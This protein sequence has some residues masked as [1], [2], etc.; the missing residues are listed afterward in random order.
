MLG[1]SLLYGIDKTAW[2]G[3]ELAS[4]WQAKSFCTTQ[5]SQNGL[6]I[7][8]TKR[9]PQVLLQSKVKINPSKCNTLTYTYRAKGEMPLR[10]QLYY[11]HDGENFSDSMKWMLPPLITDEKWHTVTLTGTALV[12]AWSWFSDEPI[13]S[14]R[15]DPTDSESGEVE[16]SEIAFT[17]TESGMMRVKKMPPLKKYT[18][19][20][21]APAWD[22]IVPGIIPPPPSKSITDY[23]YFTGS[24]ISSPLDK[25]GKGEYTR[26]NMRR[27]INLKAKPVLAMIQYTGDDNCHCLINGNNVGYMG[28]WRQIIPL[29]VTDKLVKGKN[30]FGF[31]YSNT[32]NVGG[33][34][35][36]LF[37]R[38]PDGTSEH[39]NT[40][41][42]FR[43][44]PYATTK[45]NWSV[46]NY[47]ASKWAPVIC[48]PAPPGPPW[49]AVLPYH[50]YEHSSTQILHAVTVNPQ[51]ANAGE[52]VRV[53]MEFNGKKP[54][55]PFISTI[56]LF[57][58]D[59]KLLWEE[60]REFQ[61]K[62]VKTI[63]KNSWKLVFDYEVPMYLNSNKCTLKI[64]SNIMDEVHSAQFSIK[65]LK[66]IPGFEKKPS[67]QIADNNGS[68]VIKLN[69]KQ[70]YPIW[71]GVQRNKRQDKQPIHNNGKIDIVT[72]YVEYNKV[73]S[74]PD[75]FSTN[76]YD[77]QAEAYRRNNPDAYFIV[78]I[79][80]YPPRGWDKKYPDEMCTDDNGVV[81]R[82]GGRLNHSF[83]S[84]HYLKDTLAYLEK[85]LA[86]LENCPYAN[87]IIGYRITG[88]H[89]LEWLGWDPTDTSKTLDFSPA[90][91]KAFEA[92][93]RKHYPE[94]KDF[95]IPTIEEREALDGDEILWNQHK[96]LKSVA[97]ADF[98][99]DS[100]V[101]PM[102]AL[103]KRAKQIV[104]NDKL[105]GLYYGYTMTLGASGRSQP[106]AHYTLKKVLEKANGSID[107]VISPH[108]YALRN[109]GDI[110]GD[111]KPF[112]TLAN[113]GMLAVIEDDSRTFTCAAPANSSIGLGY[114]HTFNERTTVETLR[115]NMADTLCRNYQYYFYNLSAGCE[116]D[117]PQAEKD[118]ATMRTVGQHCVENHIRRGAEVALVAS[119]ESIKAMP[120]LRKS[121]PTGE[122]LQKYL[123]DGS[124]QT[125]GQSA[126]AFT[127]DV[128][129]NNYIRFARSGAAMDY[130]LAEDL[131]DNPG[132]YKL[133]VFLNCVKY[134]DAFLK[135]IE[136][137]RERNCTML[138]IYA[139]GYYHN[140]DNGV[141][142]M[143]RLTG[144]NFK[145][146]DGPLMPS[147]T[148][149]NGRTMG[150]PSTRILPMFQVVDKNATVLGKY[151]DDSIGLAFKK[152]GNATSIYSGVWKFDVSFLTWVLKTA[153]VHVFSESSDPVDANEALFTLHARFPGLKNI[154]LPRKTTVLDIFNRKIIGKDIDAFEYEAPLHETRFFYYGDDAELLL[155]KLNASAR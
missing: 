5:R 101:N 45:G 144:F 42:D 128:L 62:E 94:L 53:T 14:L 136:K 32:D 15:L 63:D 117:F 76:E 43:T 35:G 90:C 33:C 8:I 36:E 79:Q 107:F 69:G 97:Y 17:F 113:H 77:I 121:A 120:M 27:E 40:D 1:A 48:H 31:S 104:G 24:M 122:L 138:W 124:V 111:M 87:R 55:A 154:K 119:E 133:Y 39:F 150:T 116:F 153:G 4:D 23:A 105:I 148:F 78:D 114:F 102:L 59:S 115:R 44:A 151:E 109:I 140:L 147:V 129:E 112:T 20:L 65:R 152:T 81:N 28:D 75:V 142:Y 86:Y 6:Y 127:G 118:L 126:C 155:Q 29:N 93:A 60:D 3:T 51:K 67:C 130:V 145:I 110:M 82:D 106:R 85:S 13:T 135:T 84:E 137:L 98:Y 2:R 21:D 71:G 9:D 54:A 34:I 80:C 143:N 19:A 134:D 91:Q 49:T 73:W 96:H 139:P 22:P 99:S 38:Y 146:A 108:P 70:M 58:E 57:D 12:E 47:N 68:P 61:K 50:D 30:V 41:A 52:K 25:M 100:V 37:V 88:G 95:S 26:F 74:A 125:Y 72:L 92:Y 123:I 83:S 103:C 64:Y 11:A 7:V 132:N 56:K 10:G 16:F 131:A 18:P 141:E 149:A 66:T 46:P 89:T